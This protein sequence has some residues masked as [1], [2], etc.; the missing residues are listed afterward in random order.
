MMGQETEDKYKLRLL[1]EREESLALGQTMEPKPYTLR[2][3]YSIIEEGAE[4]GE[5]TVIW[6]YTLIRAGAKVGAN[7]VIGSRVEI[8]PGAKVG[9]GTHVGAGC[10]I[11][12]PAKVGK[13]VFLAPNVFLSNDKYPAIN[14]QFEPQGVT[15]E[16]DAIISAGALIVG[17]VTI[18]RG[19]FVTMG[20][21]VTK[22]VGC[23]EMVR[24]IPARVYARRQPHYPGTAVEHWGPLCPEDHCTTCDLHHL[25]QYR[26]G[27]QEI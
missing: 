20:A 2:G 11:H 25:P 14:K 18:G 12:H 3:L 10:Q 16:D 24:G 15:I 23:G 17:G 21:V 19:A 5:G 22:D 6:H 1:R 13:R 8:G 9:E 4:V 27:P 7:C 26:T